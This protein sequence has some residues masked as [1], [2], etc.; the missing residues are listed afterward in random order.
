MNNTDYF[1]VSEQY[2]SYEDRPHGATVLQFDVQSLDHSTM[3]EHASLRML[4]PPANHEALVRIQIHLLLSNGKTRK[5][6]F[7]DSK[8]VYLSDRDPKWSEFEI[9][10][11]IKRWI[12]FEGSDDLRLEIHCP[13]CNQR[14]YK[15]VPAEPAV[16]NLLLSKDTA[17]DRRSLSHEFH[18]RKDRKT[19]CRKDSKKC[20][21]QEMNFDLDKL[22]FGF[23]IQPKR[24][25]AGICK[26]RCPPYYNAAHNHAVLQGIMWKKNKTLTPRVCC[27]PSKLTHLEVLTVDEEDPTKLMVRDLPNMIVLEC[28]CS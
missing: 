23:I 22:G 9:T 10:S 21:R 3:V 25:D 4:L 17:R 16:I 8:H 2:T 27:A 6:Y 19:D 28:A 1:I 14:N 24:F 7:V 13:K 5:R 26:G 18:F 12:S 11:A 20:C 15:I